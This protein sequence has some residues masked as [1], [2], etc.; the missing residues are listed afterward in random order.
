M[1]SDQLD[2]AGLHQLKRNADVPAARLSAAA[3]PATGQF[4]GRD[5]GNVVEFLR[6]SHGEARHGPRSRPRATADPQ[7]S[8]RHTGAAADG[9]GPD[10]GHPAGALTPLMADNLPLGI[11]G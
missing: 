4:T 2:P 8:I 9:S 5:P 10:C 3:D 11:P 1:A 7:P 6:P